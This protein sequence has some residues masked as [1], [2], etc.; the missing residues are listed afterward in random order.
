MRDKIVLID[1][2]PFT[3]RRKELFFVD[4]FFQEGY[5]FEVWSIAELLK[6]PGTY[7]DKISDNYVFEIKSLKELKQKLDEAQFD[8]TI[9]IVE[10]NS[11]KWKVYNILKH[12]KLITVR[13]NFYANTLGTTYGQAN[14]IIRV[15]F[16]GNFKK[17]LLGKLRELESSL[18][19]ELGILKDF[20]LFFSSKKEL[21]ITYQINHPDYEKWRWNANTKSLKHS[22]YFVFCDNFFPDHPDLQNYHYN[23]NGESYRKTLCNF[24]QYLEDRYGIPVIIAA[25][26]K[27]IY[28]DSDWKGRQIV[29][30][31]TDEL[32]R[33]AEGVIIH[34]SNSISYSILCDKPLCM[35]TTD[36][37][38]QI[39]TL[40]ACFS[41]YKQLFDLPIYNLDH[42]NYTEI[43][44]T[45]I[46]ESKRKKYIYTYLTSPETQD[47]HNFDIINT[48]FKGL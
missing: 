6:M 42:Q 15:F 3:K 21:G 2:E 25:H 19:K 9:F 13:I 36:D 46:E 48:V 16:K 17:L 41:A 38:N 14:W 5:R 10:I 44:F 45:Q 31:K 39:P 4:R 33:F 7:I 22:K 28:I 47:L 30:Y 8:Q 37:Y 43:K 12:Y 1:Q 18:I 34:Q 32:V 20:D 11:N 27:A 23:I 24:F 40:Q 35:V 26:P 29:K